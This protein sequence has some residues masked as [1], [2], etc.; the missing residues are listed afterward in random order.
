MRVRLLLGPLAGLAL[1]APAAARQQPPPPATEECT[2]QAASPEAPQVFY[3]R[4]EM[5]FFGRPGATFVCKDGRRIR[6]DSVARYR[7]SGV[8]HFVGNVRYSDR[9]NTLN[10]GFVQYM[11]RDRQ[12][13]AQTNVVLRDR[14][15]GSVIRAPAMHYYEATET[16]PESLVEIRQGRPHAILVQKREGESGPDTTVVDSDAMEIHGQGRFEGRGNVVLV[17]DSMRGTGENVFYDRESGDLRL[18][19]SARVE[20]PDYT[21]RGDTVS[22]RTDDQDQ[23]EQITAIGKADLDTE[24]VDVQAPLI[25]IRFAD[26]KVN[27]LIAVGLPAEEG[28]NA[29]TNQAVAVSADFRMT[30]D[31]IH[32]VAPDQQ[33]DRVTAIGSAYGE[34]L[35]ADLGNANVPALA[36]RDWMRGDTIITTFREAPADS[37]AADSARGREVESV[38]ATGGSG[39]SRAA[40][41]YRVQDE[42]DPT[43]PVAINYL[44]ARRIVVVMRGGEVG[45]VEP[46]GEVQGIYLQP[47]RRDSQTASRTAAGGGRR[48]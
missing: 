16:R 21:L 24:D 38:V 6:A 39:A 31:S 45:T 27:E 5:A 33:L 42:E 30:A 1:V 36:A 43:A 8:V 41:L 12:A 28:E 46:D 37:M 48:P 22:G 29:I 7:A 15:T 34:R 3:N 47:I 44:L 4:G 26:G 19:V 13:I 2:V 35:G 25:R 32:A 23:L 20:T 14:E 40:S 11:E 17:R 9:D 18:W 10:A